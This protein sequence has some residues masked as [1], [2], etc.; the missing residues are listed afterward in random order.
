M[1]VMLEH[2]IDKSIHLICPIDAYAHDVNS[3]NHLLKYLT[4]YVIHFNK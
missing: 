4:Y 1:D 3:S 2:T